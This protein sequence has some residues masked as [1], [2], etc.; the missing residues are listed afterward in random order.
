ML[1]ISIMFLTATFSNKT[2]EAAPASCLPSDVEIKLEWDAAWY[3]FC[4]GG[5]GTTCT[6]IIHIPT[7]N[8]LTVPDAEALT[9]STFPS[10]S[11]P[12]ILKEVDQNWDATEGEAQE[13]NEHV[14][15]PE[16]ATIIQVL[17]GTFDQGIVIPAQ[18]V[19]YSSQYNGF[20]GYCVCD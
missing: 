13:I 6:V 3:F 15:S 2:V 12:I 11:A 18:T 19:V 20:I 4:L 5:S 10:G 8:Q 9:G 14:Y 16:D 7:D 17:Q 1:L